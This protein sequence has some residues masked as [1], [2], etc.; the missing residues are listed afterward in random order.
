MMTLEDLSEPELLVWEAIESGAL[1]DLSS[2]TTK[3]EE[4]SS[5]GASWGS[6]RTIR[7]GVL[8]ELLTSHELP[9]RR[10]ARAV[11]LRCARIQGALDLNAMT[12]LCP[13]DLENC[14]FD[15][16]LRL[17]EART[18]RITLQDCHLPAL[19]ARQLET[20]GD[21][22]LS[23]SQAYL[24]DLNS[25]HISGEL[26]LSS[27][28]FSNPGGS[29]LNADR[30]RV[31]GGVFCMGLCTEGTLRLRRADIG[32]GL[33]F[34]EAHL[35]D[36]DGTALDA[37]GL[38]VDGDMFI[39]GGFRAE[40][41]ISL[42]SAH[43]SGELGLSDSHLCNPGGQAFNADTLR[44]SG[45]MLC[46]GGLRIDGEMRLMS[47]HII[48]QLELS[49][50]L[51]SNP[52]GP[53]LTADGLQ[54]EG[55]MFCRSNVRSE[56][57]MHMPGAHI[58]GHLVFTGVHLVNPDGRALTADR[59]RVDG[60]MFWRADVR[61][62]GEVRL[63]GA[64]IGSQL[65]FSYAHL[66]NAEGPA[67]NAYRARI[68]GNMLCGADLRVEG[69]L[70]LFGVHITGEL[71]LAY[72]A[73]STPDGLALDLE[74][75]SVGRLILPSNSEPKG[76]LNLTNARV[77]HLKDAWPQHPYKACLAELVYETLSFDDS[78]LPA[79]LE[80]LADAEEGYLPH[81]YEQL[82]VVLRRAGHEDAARRVAI[83]KERRRRDQLTWM[84]RV[85]NRFLGLTVGY[86]YQV[87]RGALVL[88]LFVLAGWPIFAWAKAHHH[89]NALHKEQP[90][91][92]FHALLYSLDTVLP[93]INLGQKG[94]WSPTGLAQSWYV[95]SVLAGWIMVTV[96][97]AALTAR[98]VR[99]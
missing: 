14:F 99:D 95:L 17:D 93:V 33:R 24:V 19:T 36:P 55:D 70:R 69:E 59:L 37:S 29:A 67:L 51:I 75:A 8:V 81:A 12:L 53:T 47:A 9:H 72:A 76:V 43:I 44:V 92:Q 50:I 35:S 42:N 91:P 18:L 16:P 30:L 40:G 88:G 74:G 87:W 66:S 86:G 6:Q 21:L 57:D 22:I 11:R 3:D 54:V 60:G 64:H 80:W 31:Q 98:L 63:L 84:G 5:K 68:D 90:Q 97:L 28:Y 61:T 7:A 89:M 1:V 13:L 38:R 39:D 58:S 65:E 32:G 23:R 20:R 71:D 41:E 56:G 34:S 78:E 48:G 73:I 83:A 46:R 77:G 79:R 85:W 96:I 26:D 94:Y 10:R 4:D 62:E 49:G 25:A 82:S 2:N 27:S 15:E 52:G 45:N